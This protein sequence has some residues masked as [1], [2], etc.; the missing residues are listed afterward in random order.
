MA[1]ARNRNIRADVVGSM[2]R[3]P[4]LLLAREQ[5][6]QQQISHADFKEIEDQ[7][8]NACIAIQEKAGVDV[9]TDGEVRRNVFA[10]QLVQAT[11]GFGAVSGNFVDWFDSQGNLQR[12]S[13]TVALV[14]R[15]KR[16]R[17]LSAEEFSYLRGR[18]SKPTKIT[19]PSPTMYAY[20]WLPGVSDKVYSTTSEYLAEVT[21]ILKDE[22]AELARLGAT[23]I[24]FDAP[25]FGMLID[26][27]QQRW[28][29][30]KGF[31]PEKLIDDG[32]R[33]IFPRGHIQDALPRRLP[34]QEGSPNRQEHDCSH[35]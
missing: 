10:S 5:L 7:A 24:Q 13:V 16:K 19:L 28:F 21:G 8:A 2:L 17:H 33:L 34:G 11:E 22:V 12:D 4:Y 14:S 25:E 20:Y 9:V 26:P 18:T 15:I 29:K 32:I 35:S 31:D 6:K 1:N 23:Y 30:G 27:H 3:P